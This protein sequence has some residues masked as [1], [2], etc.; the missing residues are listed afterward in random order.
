MKTDDITLAIMDMTNPDEIM[1]IQSACSHRITS[2]AQQVHFAP[3]VTKVRLKPRFQTKAPFNS[4]GVVQK[5]NGKT[6]KVIFEGH[7]GTWSVPKTIVDIV[8]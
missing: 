4:V 2:L 1:R 5:V 8:N 3:S 6:I 7:F